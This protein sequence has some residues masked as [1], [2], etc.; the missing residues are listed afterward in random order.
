MLWVQIHMRKVNPKLIQGF[1]KEIKSLPEEIIDVEGV[2]IKTCPNVFPPTSQFS[3]SSKKLYTVFGDLTGKC[4]LDMGTGTG[5]QAIHAALADARHVIAVDI[6][7]DAVT[8]AM[9]NVKL[10]K[11]EAQV[12]VM[13]SDLFK[14][15]KLKHFF[16]VIIANLPITDY[17]IEGEV[18][19]ALYD[20]D[21]KLH[22]RFFKEVHKFL[23]PS[24]YTILSHANFN[25][26]KDF[27][28]LEEMIKENNL[29]VD[30]YVE[31]DAL[32]YTWRLYRLSSSK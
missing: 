21:Y 6:N 14:A 7:D 30:T 18:E 8:C 28:S 24:G 19:C 12:T 27:E 23:S 32:G 13:K 2:K 4:V 17:P 11:L 26:E 5:V 22:K 10:N 31:E 15:V 1:L 25:G 3:N 29:K 20:P 9:E 16:D